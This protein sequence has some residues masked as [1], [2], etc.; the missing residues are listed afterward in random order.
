MFSAH[1]ESTPPRCGGDVLIKTQWLERSAKP[2]PD[3]DRA[4][5][6]FLGPPSRWTENWFAWEPWGPWGAA[7]Y[8]TLRKTLKYLWFSN[9]ICSRQ[10]TLEFIW[11]Q[12]RE[13]LAAPQFLY[14]HYCMYYNNDIWRSVIWRKC[15]CGPWAKKK[16]RWSLGLVQIL[17]FK[18]LSSNPLVQI[19]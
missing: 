13:A 6:V 11:C 19:L 15:M 7:G 3:S 18:S 12:E 9:G 8:R 4:D 5:V 17:K 10:E 16:S 2:F 14:Y 1:L